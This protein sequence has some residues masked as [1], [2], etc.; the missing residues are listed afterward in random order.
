[1]LSYSGV[2]WTSSIMLLQLSSILSLLP[3]ISAYDAQLQPS[4]SI[5]YSE[6]VPSGPSYGSAVGTAGSNS[7]YGPSFGA[8]RGAGMPANVF[9]QQIPLYS[10]GRPPQNIPT[11]SSCYVDLKCFSCSP[12]FSIAQ[13][14]PFERRTPITCED[15]LQLCLEKQSAD[16]PYCCRAVVYDFAYRTCD[17]FA[18][19]GKS[20]PQI[21]TKYETRSYFVPTGQC[22]AKKEPKKEAA[23]LCKEGELP[24]I[25]EV[26]GYTDPDAREAVSLSGYTLKDCATACLDNKDAEG[27]PLEM[28]SACASLIYEGTTCKLDDTKIEVLR[29]LQP[30]ADSTYM[31]VQCFPEKLVS[32]CPNNFIYAP[33]HVLVGFAKTVITT[34]SEGEC[35]EKCL[36]STEDLGFYCK[37]GMFYQEDRNENCILNTE[38]RSTQPNVYTEDEAAVV[39]F[40]LGCGRSGRRLSKKFYKNFSQALFDLPAVGLWTQWS[41]CT[42]TDGSSIRYRAC[43]EKDIRN[44]PKEVKSCS[45]AQK[46]PMKPAAGRFPDG[47]LRKRKKD[48]PVLKRQ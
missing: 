7:G 40:E 8:D 18:V 29:N 12:G 6:P 48:E 15:C 41:P 16:Y 32:Q 36:T 26:S 38:S 37:S 20:Q 13:G 5:S 14:F 28:E 46:L 39:Y 25:I 42:T 17:L 21:V 35:V 1:M 10:F 2:V 9:Q 4:Q 43:R 47:D 24:K 27:R 3:W 19:D 33:G 44:C 30:S 31:M 11:A 45:N 23:A 34:S 22:G